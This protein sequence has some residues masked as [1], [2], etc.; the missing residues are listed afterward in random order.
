MFLPH[1][2]HQTLKISWCESN[3]CD[4]EL[5]QFHWDWYEVA[6]CILLPWG[7]GCGNVTYNNFTSMPYT[8]C[9][10]WNIIFTFWFGLVNVIGIRSHACQMCYVIKWLPLIG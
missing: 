7:F 9:F 6:C 1:E 3:T 5:S 4:Y 8:T 2:L 10:R